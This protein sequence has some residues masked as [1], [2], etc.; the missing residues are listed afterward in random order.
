[1]KTL[2]AGVTTVIFNILFPSR[3]FLVCALT[4][5]SQGDQGN[6]SAMGMEC[7][8]YGWTEEVHSGFWW[9]N[10]SERGYLDCLRFVWENIIKMNLKLSLEG[11]VVG[12]A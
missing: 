5:Y 8:K 3:C 9:G 10:L 4:K 12:L 6:Y 7:E 2:S 11:V 1:M